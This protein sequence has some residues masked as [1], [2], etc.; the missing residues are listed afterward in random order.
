MIT[1]S[2]ALALAAGLT[3]VNPAPAAAGPACPEV[4]GHRV[5]C[6]TV[7]RPLVPGEPR[8]GAIEVAYALVARREPH[9][10]ARGTIVVNP[11]GPGA[12]PIAWAGLYA[13][14]LAPVLSDHD[15][16][17]IDPRGT[18]R[19]T[20]LT[21]G[22]SS[23]PLMVTPRADLLRRVGRCGHRLGPRAEGY[24][25][26]ATADD[27]DAVRAEL[28]IPKVTLLGQ[29]Y[30]TYL[31][32]EYARRHPRTVESIVLSGAY[33]LDFDSLGRPSAQAV[34][35]AL[36]RICARSGA[37]DGTRAVR[38]LATVAARLRHSPAEI[39][40]TVGGKSRTLR[41]TED[42]LA[43]LIHSVASDNVGAEPGEVPLLG[44][45]PHALHRA[46]RGDD[47]PLAGLV[48]KATTGSPAQ[49]ADLGQ[50]MAVICNDYPRTWPVNASYAQRVRAYER[51]LRNTRPGEF[52]AFSA[53]GFAA[54]QG[55]AGDVCLRWPARSTAGPDVTGGRFPDVPVLV[56]SGDLDAKTPDA[57]GR[58][59][60]AQFRG[61]VFVSVPNT[62][63]LPEAEPSGCVRGIISA[64]I[65]DKKVGDTSCLAAIP[66]VK[67][68]PVR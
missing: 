40:V 61:G 11:G 67:V 25:S 16:L 60:A 48:T 38:D 59:A 64:F 45:L 22:V 24:T 14:G 20:P 63:H 57:N 46:A 10:P 43:F 47:R 51:A 54:A 39:P 15:L 56:L 31:M 44:E 66:P 52:G 29:S 8:L 28:G 37:C 68:L 26:A 65:R 3:F 1:T 36:H 5:V 42:K 12:A 23:G 6:G 18:G 17:V 58:R 19:S 13:Q 62:G 49:F 7:T 27:F 4:P 35:P 55:D 33:P 32:A 34:S 9:R 2:A 30:G 41:F 50:P 53:K 21:C